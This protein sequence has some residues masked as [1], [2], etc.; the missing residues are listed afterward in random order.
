MEVSSA[1]GFWARAYLLL[2]ALPDVKAAMLYSVSVPTTSGHASEILTDRWRMLGS[3]EA[4]NGM[5]LFGLSTAFLFARI[6]ELCSREPAEQTVALATS[7]NA[8]G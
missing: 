8:P 2:R 7:A 4:L 3:L 1:A 5:L 6:Q